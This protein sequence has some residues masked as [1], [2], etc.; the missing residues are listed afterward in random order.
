M[1]IGNILAGVSL[2]L[3]LGRAPKPWEVY[4]SE[5]LDRSCLRDARCTKKSG[6]RD[7]RLCSL[8]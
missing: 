1:Y 6:T 3:Y 5:S 7:D 2:P 8:A 4:S